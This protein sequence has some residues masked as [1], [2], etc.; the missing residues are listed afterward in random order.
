[1]NGIEFVVDK[2]KEFLINDGGDPGYLKCFKK[3]GFMVKWK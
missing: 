2:F 3:G 1:L